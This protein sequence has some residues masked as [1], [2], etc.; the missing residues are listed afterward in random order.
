M[1]GD[2]RL[3]SL[4]VPDLEQRLNN[5]IV[6]VVST[7]HENAVMVTEAY[8]IECIPKCNALFIL[9]FQIPS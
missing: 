5:K 3:E 7:H 2:V 9:V 6:V 1:L 4:N 8:L